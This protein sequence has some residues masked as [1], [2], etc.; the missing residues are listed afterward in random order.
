MANDRDPSQR[1]VIQALR[2]LVIRAIV[3]LNG[4]RVA[5][6]GGPALPFGK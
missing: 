1:R 3:R 2:R 5:V 6:V 4:D